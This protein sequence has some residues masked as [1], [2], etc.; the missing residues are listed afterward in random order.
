M[1]QWNNGMMEHWNRPYGTAEAT[2]CVVIRGGG[3]ENVEPGREIGSRWAGPET[4]N[5]GR[6]DRI[7]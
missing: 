6:D 5:V 7:G 4:E 2:L 1:E 3:V